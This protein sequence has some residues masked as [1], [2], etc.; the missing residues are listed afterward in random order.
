MRMTPEKLELMENLFKQ[1]A[2]EE[3]PDRF[4]ELTRELNELLEAFAS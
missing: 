4:I 3:D 2:V 1:I